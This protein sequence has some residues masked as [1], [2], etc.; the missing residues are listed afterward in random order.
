[1]TTAAAAGSAVESPAFT[2]AILESENRTRNRAPLMAAEPA[3]DHTQQAID[4]VQKLGRA[5]H[6][7]GAPAH[8]LEDVL[9]VLSSD[10]GLRGEFFS[11]PSA[12]FY[13]Y[14]LPEE[15]GVAHLQRVFG[16]DLDL[17]K[18]SRLDRVFNQVMEDRL[19]LA[20]AS[21]EVDRIE[22]AP[23]RYPA[24]ATWIAFATTSFA[25]ARLSPAASPK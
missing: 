11:T 14:D 19:D 1:M 15:R 6:R 4:F 8:R 7:Y 2:V 20:A 16:Q 22:A 24:W 17:E 25:A 21:A 5:L 10:L 12:I 3:A 9:Q 23:P 13:A 18:L